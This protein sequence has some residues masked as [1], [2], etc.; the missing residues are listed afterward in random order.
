MKILSIDLKLSQLNFLNFNKQLSVW[1]GRGFVLPTS[2]PIDAVSC[3]CIALGIIFGLA[4]F[5]SKRIEA[6]K[7]NLAAKDKE[8]STLKTRINELEPNINKNIEEVAEKTSEIAR[9]N[10]I[11]AEQAIEIAQLRDEN[12]QHAATI[13]ENEKV[14]ADD[15][16]LFAEQGVA[17]NND[18]DAKF[19]MNAMIAEQASVI[20]QQELIITQ[21]EIERTHFSSD[22]Y[23]VDI[24][25]IHFRRVL[26]EVLAAFDGLKFSFDQMLEKNAHLHSDKLELQEELQYVQ[27]LLYCAKK[28]RNQMPEGGIDD[29]YE[30]F[31]TP[32]KGDLSSSWQEV[33]SEA[34]TTLIEEGNKHLISIHTATHEQLTSMIESIRPHEDQ[35][36]KTVVSIIWALMD[37]AKKKIKLLKKEPSFAGMKMEILQHC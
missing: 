27:N 5:I 29:D 18:Q 7:D 26:D 15:E 37:I 30:E 23:E 28:A 4:Y 36:Q 31:A 14:L 16:I 35:I 17:F 22:L 3:S 21:L 25:R 32:A 34:K 33:S 9:L 20:A 13:A 19:K 8:I 6:L 24:E 11:N 10:G 12:A 1:S 2:I